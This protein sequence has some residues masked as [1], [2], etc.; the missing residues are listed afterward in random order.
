MCS[1]RTQ[2]ILQ[3][4][5]KHFSHWQ[6]IAGIMFQLPIHTILVN[7]ISQEYLNKI[8]IYQI[9]QD[10]LLRKQIKSLWSEVKAEGHHDI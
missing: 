4:K 1:Y 9:R 10:V 6:A 7:A 3:N 8:E 2:E 5:K